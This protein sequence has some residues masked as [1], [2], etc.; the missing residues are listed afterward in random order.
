LIASEANA[1]AVL[2]EE[3][4]AKG[5]VPSLV[6]KTLELFLVITAWSP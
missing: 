5:I 2:K 6:T 1:C 4:A 3:R